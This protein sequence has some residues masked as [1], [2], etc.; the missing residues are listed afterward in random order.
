MKF[1]VL[2]VDDNAINLSL[3]V[4]LLL[5]IDG[6]STVSFTDAMK[7]LIW[8]E[9]NTPDL[10]LI[11]YVMP[12][13]DGLEFIKRFRALPKEMIV[14]VI[15]VTAAI[16]HGVRLR[17]LELHANDFINKP[18]DTV[19]F[20]AR[21]HNMLALRQTQENLHEISNDKK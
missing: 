21:V 5:K 6:I 19:E 20:T 10:L 2:V 15:M 9:S 1:T 7:A 3:T 13:L 18:L 12:V 16:E 11:D 17:A 4:Q 8:C 14:P